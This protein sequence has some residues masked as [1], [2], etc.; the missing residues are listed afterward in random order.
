MSHRY[1]FVA[2]AG[3]GHIELPKEIASRLR[4]KGIGR[5]RVVITS[6]AEEEEGLTAR[7]IDRDQIDGVASAQSIDRDI[8]THVLGGEGIAHGSELGARLKDLLNR[9]RQQNR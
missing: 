8:A 4:L 3:D 7:G 9:S 6:M 1:E 5:V 2:D